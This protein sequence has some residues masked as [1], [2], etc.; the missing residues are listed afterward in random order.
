MIALRN[1]AKKAL[2]DQLNAQRFH[3]FILLQGIL[4]PALIREA[5]MDQFVPAEK[6]IRTR[7]TVQVF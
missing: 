3:D 2:G 5:V 6:K 4:P 7:N 1:D